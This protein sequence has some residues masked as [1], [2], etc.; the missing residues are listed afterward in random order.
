MRPTSRRAEEAVSEV[1][2]YIL[3]LFLSSAILMISL[4]V[5]MVSRTATA[6]L[7]A[8]TELRL[9]A[10]RIASAVGEAGFVA[11]SLPNATYEAQVSLPDLGG[12]SYYLNA[13][14]GIIFANTTDGAVRANATA[15]A[16]ESYPNLQ[17]SGSVYSSQTVTR[18]LYSLQASG[19]R[20]ITLTT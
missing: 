11:S 17:L 5:F 12:R 15:F 14:N 7:Q 9:V 1:L 18:V 16:V 3:M 4:Q 2:G 8:G 10:E 20:S 13:S 19:A 6:D